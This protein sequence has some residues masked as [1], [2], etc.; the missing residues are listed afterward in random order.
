MTH[1]APVRRPAAHQTAAVA[2]AS[3]AV[4]VVAATADKS[5]CHSFSECLLEKSRVTLENKLSFHT[6]IMAT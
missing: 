5:C 1:S 4:F 3:A 6:Q 2:A